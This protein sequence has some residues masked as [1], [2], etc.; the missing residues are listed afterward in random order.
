MAGLNLTYTIDL[1][2]LSLALEHIENDVNNELRLAL[3]ESLRDVQHYARQN[4]DFES[5]SHKLEQAINYD[6]GPDGLSGRVFIDETLAP[7]GKWVH[8]G[9]KEHF[10]RP[11][12]ARALHWVEGG[13]EFFSSGHEVSGIT[14]DP[15]LINALLAQ[16]SNIMTRINNAIDKVLREAGL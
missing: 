4:H 2:R 7:Y 1:S 14:A 3:K 8:D 13:N 6:I 10:V 5:H 12:N 9:T 16:D 15:F 11:R